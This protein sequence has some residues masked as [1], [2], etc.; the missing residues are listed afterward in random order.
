MLTTPTIHVYRV[1]YSDARIPYDSWK[2]MYEGCQNYTKEQL[3]TE[4][5]ELPL[6]DRTSLID[7]NAHVMFTLKTAACVS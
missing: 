6:E 3:M 2:Y 4:M 1:S 7:H 5:S